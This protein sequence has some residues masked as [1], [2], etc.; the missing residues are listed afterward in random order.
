MFIVIPQFLVTGLSSVIFAIFEPG[1]SVAHEGNL[2]DAVANNATASVV[3]GAV[4]FLVREAVDGG[5]A[6]KGF[7]TIGFIFR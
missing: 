1:K 2:G 4:K 6:P 3:Q 7:D 5:A